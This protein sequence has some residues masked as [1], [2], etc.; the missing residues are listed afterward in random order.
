MSCVGAR[1]LLPLSNGERKVCG[2]P[3]PRALLK[4]DDHR[5]T[6]NDGFRKSHPEIPPIVGVRGVAQKQNL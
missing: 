4:A 5:D 2:P 6:A 3:P 1:R